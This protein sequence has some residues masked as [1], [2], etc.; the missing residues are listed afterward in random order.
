MG[1]RKD[2]ERIRLYKPPAVCPRLKCGGTYF[3]LHEDGWQCWNCM[4]IIYKDSPLPLSYNNLITK[5]TEKVVL[6]KTSS[7]LE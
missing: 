7:N 6:C 5:V 2:P 1:N 3:I 4:K